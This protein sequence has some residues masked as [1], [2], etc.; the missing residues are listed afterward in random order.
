MPIPPATISFHARVRV[1]PA[2]SVDVASR[3]KRL[4]ALLP[5]DSREGCLLELVPE[6]EFLTYGVGVSLRTMA[7]P[8]AARAHAPV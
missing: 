3:S 5:P 6:G 4:A 7:T 2:G 8:A 1:H